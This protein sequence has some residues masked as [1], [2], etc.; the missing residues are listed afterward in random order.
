MQG[1]FLFALITTLYVYPRF[2]VS[3]LDN[4][5]F[6]TEAQSTQRKK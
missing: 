6:T 1:S 2:A 3:S 5:F 4:H